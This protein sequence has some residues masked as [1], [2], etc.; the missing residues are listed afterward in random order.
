MSKYIDLLKES[1]E[2]WIMDILWETEKFLK[3]IGARI[4][5]SK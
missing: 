5:I 3:E 2:S 4:L 1:K